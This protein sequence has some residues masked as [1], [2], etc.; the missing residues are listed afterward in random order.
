[1]ASHNF[2]EA[3]VN[4]LG[5]VFGDY[6]Y[7]SLLTGRPYFLEMMDDIKIAEL[8]ARSQD[9]HLPRQRLTLAANGEAY[10]LALRFE[11]LDPQVAILATDS[12]PVLNWSTLA[13]DGQEQWPI[14]FLMP[15]GAI[16]KEKSRVDRP[17]GL[18]AK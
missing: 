8:F 7:N 3:Y 13:T 14:A 1:M 11:D 5:S 6:V 17:E 9:S 4:P 15:S 16:L 12:A 18:P 2:D 10:G